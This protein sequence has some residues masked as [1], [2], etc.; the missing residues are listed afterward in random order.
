MKTTGKTTIAGKTV[1]TGNITIPSAKRNVLVIDNSNVSTYISNNNLTFDVS[2]GVEI[3]DWRVTS[4]VTIQ[5]IVTSGSMARYPGLRP[6]YFIVRTPNVLTFRFNAET[7]WGSLTAT[8]RLE[9]VYNCLVTNI[10]MYE[11]HYT[12]IGAN[13]N[14]V[15]YD[16]GGVTGG[17]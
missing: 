10:G 17:F 11:F 3:I 6:L 13:N 7:R 14:W 16:W 12:L 5:R 1:V 15:T 4:A 9:G 2:L 8:G